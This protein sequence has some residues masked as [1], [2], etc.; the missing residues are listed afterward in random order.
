MM[1]NFR[2]DLGQRAN[3]KEL[4]ENVEKHF[5]GAEIQQVMPIPENMA[6]MLVEVNADD[7]P[8]CC[9]SRDTNWPTGL[10]VVKL[11]D[12][13]G[14][15]PIDLVEGDLKIEAQL[16]NRHKCGKCGR[17]MKIL[18]KPG[19][20]GFEA[21]YRC[22]CCDRTVKLNPDGSEEDETHE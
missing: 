9:D 21:K 17:E 19:Q 14:C 7:E 12:G 11:K 1:S 13:V 20:E 10:A 22:E 2:I 5:E 8:V 4:F 15:Y 3:D 6:V 18:L 16:V